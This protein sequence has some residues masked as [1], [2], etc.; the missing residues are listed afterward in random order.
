MASFVTSMVAHVVCCILLFIFILDGHVNSMLV[1]LW[2]LTFAVVGVQRGKFSGTPLL[3]F[4]WWSWE[5][6]LAWYESG[7]YGG[8]LRSGFM[9]C[10]VS[11]TA[12]WAA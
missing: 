5:L 12:G 1:H 8:E 9:I 7:A 2:F 4:S 10:W 6:S 11:G 3:V